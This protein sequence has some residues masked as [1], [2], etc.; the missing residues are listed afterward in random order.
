MQNND[1]KNC[2]KKSFVYEILWR[3]ADKWTLIILD[4][5]EWWTLRFW[6]LQKNIWNI[7]QKMLTQTLKELERDWLIS[8]KSY[9]TVP[10]K[11]EYSLTELWYNLNIATCSIWL[12]VENN[13]ENIIKN[14]KNIWK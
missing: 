3:I 13:M 11:V 4:E 7:S 14:R 2:D 12:W 8:R 1:K 10:P 9:P 5:L 6:E